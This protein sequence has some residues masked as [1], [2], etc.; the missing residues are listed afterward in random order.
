[1]KIS[2]GNPQQEFEVIIDSGS[3]LLWI[4]SDECSN[5][6]Y[7]N[8][9]FNTK[10][11]KT[12]KRTAKSYNL[13]YISGKVSGNV[14]QDVVSLANG[15]A[16]S[17]FNFLL[18]NIVDAPVKVDGIIGFARRYQ[19]YPDDF[20]LME[21]L[22]KNKI[23]ERKIFAQKILDSDLLDTN[24]PQNTDDSRFILTPSISTVDESRK[25]INTNSKFY[26]GDLPEEVKINHANFTTC[27]SLNTPSS[28]ANF[29]SCGLTGLLFRKKFSNKSIENKNNQDEIFKNRNFINADEEYNKNSSEG[30]NHITPAI[31]DTGSNVILAPPHYSEAF[32][33]VFF[34]KAIKK[35]KCISL[36]D[37]SGSYGFQCHNDVSF[38]NDFPQILFKFDNGKI[39]EISNKLLFTYDDT[40]YTF[41][42]IFAH[43]PG[44][45]WLLGQ[46]FLKNFLMVFDYEND[47]IGFYTDNTNEPNN[48]ANNYVNESKLKGKFYNEAYIQNNNLIYEQLGHKSSDVNNYTYNTQDQLSGF[49]IFLVIL[50]TCV[51]S[52]SIV[53]II[54]FFVKKC[55]RSA[56]KLEAKLNDDYG[57]QSFFNMVNNFSAYFVIFI[58]HY[59]LL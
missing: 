32:K 20:S 35:G 49:E 39:Y 50:S 53:F 13:N 30:S 7:S 47:S 59:N 16:L 29:W 3:Y 57:K 56:T 27:K 23:I 42:I 37:Y 51:F 6:Y 48:A 4:P 18:S 24:N 5:C 22:Y 41:K 45:G 21:Q 14:S 19:N 25:T 12:L 17:G 40:K 54:R 1:M 46:P 36:Q 15:L 52:M 8:N 44:N 31:F 33:R 11:S 10:F 43:V 26:I 58:L 28:V 2:L 55:N 9:K 38:E 34:A